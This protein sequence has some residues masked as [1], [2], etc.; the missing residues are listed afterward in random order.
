MKGDSASYYASTITKRDIVCFGNTITVDRILRSNGGA[1]LIVADSVNLNAPIDTRIYFDHS[2]IYWPYI[3]DVTGGHQTDLGFW[4]DGYPPLRPAYDEYYLKQ[5]FYVA[6]HHQYEWAVAVDTPA[7]SRSTHQLQ[8]QTNLLS[9]PQLPFGFSHAP[10]YGYA[11]GDRGQDA[12]TAPDH[13]ALRS[14]DITLVVNMLN[15][16]D[17]CGATAAGPPDTENGGIPRSYRSM[18]NANGATGGRGAAGNFVAYFGLGHGFNDG[19]LKPGGVSGA[20]SQGSDA[21]D[22]EVFGVNDSIGDLAGG[23]V[24]AVTTVQGGKAPYG[25]KLITGP[26]PNFEKYPYVNN[27]TFQ[28]YADNP[29]AFQLSEVSRKDAESPTL[30]ELTGADGTVTVK[31][32]LT[33]DQAVNVMSDR[34]SMLA[35]HHYDAKYM[36]DATAMGDQ[37]VGAYVPRSQL[38]AYWN[39]LLVNLESQL[40]GTTLGDLELKHGEKQT[41]LSHSPLM[42]TISCG[43][44]WATSLNE[45]ERRLIGHFCEYDPAQTAP[46]SNY[47]RH[48]GG[49][50]A[51][52]PKGISTQ[53][54][55]L[56]AQAISGGILS[57]LDQAVAVLQQISDNQ[58]TQMENAS[59][60]DL[61]GHLGSL[62][63]SADALRAKMDAPGDWHSTIAPV[64]GVVQA[65]VGASTAL[66]SVYGEPS[67]T[68]VDD[69]VDKIHGVYKAWENYQA[70]LEG[71][72]S[73]S[74]KYEAL[75]AEIQRV[76]GELVAFDRAL[77]DRRQKSASMESQSLE[78]YVEDREKVTASRRALQDAYVPMYR[79]ALQRYVGAPDTTREQARGELRY[80]ADMITRF[81]NDQASWTYTPQIDPCKGMTP[82]PRFDARTGDKRCVTVPA[83]QPSVAVLYSS[84]YPALPLYVARPGSVEGYAPL[85]AV[86][87]THLELQIQPMDVAAASKP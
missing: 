76:Q 45:D 81:P 26:L 49:L 62:K 39:D 2:D 30:T 37:Y 9:S 41:A 38:D 77:N 42:R 69:A 27:Q 60:K 28:S 57:R 84:R 61:S 86:G 18:L 87:K 66:G 71:D 34:I 19:E 64:E 6:A 21:G 33:S 63:A 74:S 17:Q 55:D 53:L 40:L 85:G 72:Q 35:L 58:L 59:R 24:A 10:V 16:C 46:L 83:N 75:M 51:E 80:I 56:K 15:L 48:Q 52:V 73:S 70:A 78:N 79:D 44:T 31:A 68:G 65:V 50:Y 32:G 3:D 12:P 25:G 13:R 22:V 43:Q 1:V 23:N 47:W 11:Y 82:R 5:E 14:G 67:V 7:R 36:G 54:E 8:H 4:I 20:A 29:G